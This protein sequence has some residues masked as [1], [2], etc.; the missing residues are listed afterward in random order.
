[1]GLRRGVNE[2]RDNIGVSE[3]G[4]CPRCGGT[5][6]ASSMNGYLQCGRCSYEFPD[7]NRTSAS[8]GPPPNHRRDA[9]LIQE[10]NREMESGQLK[11]VLGIEKGL[12]SEQEASLARLQDK[13]MVGMQGQ[14]NAA[15]DERTPLVISFDDD[16]NLVETVV[17]TL[18]VVE[19]GF[20]GGE[21]VRIE[22]PGVGTEFYVYDE[23]SPTGWKRGRSASDT[24]RSIASVINRS[25]RIVYARSNGTRIEFEMRDRSMSDEGLVIFVDDPGGTDLVASKRGVAMDARS[26]EVIEDYHAV[27]AIVLEDG[28]ISPSEDQLLWAMRQNLGITEEEH[29]QYVID[30]IGEGAVKECTSCGGGSQLYPEYLAWYCGACEAWL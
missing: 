23:A 28:I 20:D 27:L 10:F 24:A 9:E 15:S 3:E 17:A 30:H 19:N 4:D 7:P 18:D 16:D 29:V 2:A 25:S 12:S 14:Y 22:Y 5:T 26:A 21:E 6:Q 8:R 1:M 13:W 11:S